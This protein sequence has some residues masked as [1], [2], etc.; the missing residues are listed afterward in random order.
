MRTFE[1]FELAFGKKYSTRERIVRRAHF[2]RSLQRVAAHNAG[3]HSWR[4]G[5]NQFSDLSD[6]EFKSKVLMRPQKCSATNTVGVPGGAENKKKPADLP[7]SIDWRSRGIV[8][9]VK[10]QGADPVSSDR[11]PSTQSTLDYTQVAA[12]AAGR[13]LR[14]ELSK[15]IWRLRRA[16]GA[17]LGCRSSSS[18]I[19]R[20]PS[21]LRAATAGYRRTLLNTSSTRAGSRRSFLTPTTRRTKSVP[22]TPRPRPRPRSPTASASACRVAP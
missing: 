2:E 10:N 7:P 18:S 11:S 6:E 16:R 9:E 14:R 4:A 1:D 12:E 17:R 21:I 8:S 20:A 13:S 19:V 22:S 5:I 15:L 3:E